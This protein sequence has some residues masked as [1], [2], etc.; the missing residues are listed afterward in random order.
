L[1]FRIV[2]V[3]GQETRTQVEER[4]VT[5]AEVRVVTGDKS[6]AFVG[7][8]M[9]IETNFQNR[10]VK[11]AFPLDP[12][13]VP[14][15]PAAR[16]RFI[17]SLAVY[18][19]HSDGD[20]E[21]KRGT[22]RYDADGNP[23]AIE[24]GIDKFSTFVIITA[25]AEQAEHPAYVFGYPDGTFRPNNPITRAEAAT[26]LSR[27]L[28]PERADSGLVATYTDIDSNYWAFEA[29]RT[30]GAAGLMVGDGGRFRPDETI[31]R[32]ELA[33]VALRWKQQDV[34][35]DFGSAMNDIR[36]HWA[37]AAIE[38]A[39]HSGWMRGY[40]D[41]SFGPDRTLTRAEMVTTMNRLLGRD[42]LHLSIAEPTWQDVPS[43][44]WAYEAIEEASRTHTVVAAQSGNNP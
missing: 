17:A 31:T 20:K 11:V 37:Q 7:T 33:A 8:P 3:R 22:I 26:I 30:V 6:I 24:I 44:Y 23:V 16:E 36:G 15:D 5:A 35:A 43:D 14:T 41:G 42:T 19:E 13:S 10:P 29:I 28:Q 39:V 32:A 38:T 34:R 12:K 27:L 25:E 9:T 18:V 1:Y 2:P 21:L 40:E 4:T